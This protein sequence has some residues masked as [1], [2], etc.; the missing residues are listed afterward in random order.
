MKC[1]AF[2]HTV[3]VVLSLLLAIV[4]RGEHAPFVQTQNGVSYVSGGVGSDE[5]QAIKAMGEHFNLQVS[6][7]TL[8]G[9]YMGGGNVT[10][11]DAQGHTLLSTEAVGPLFYAQLKPGTYTV[12]VSGNGKDMQQMATLGVAGHQA[13]TFTWSA[14]EDASDP[15]RSR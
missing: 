1:S 12:K 10:I 13:L 8:A 4:A 9:A 11:L 7:T 2:K 15:S 14:A 6:M 3:I 5:V